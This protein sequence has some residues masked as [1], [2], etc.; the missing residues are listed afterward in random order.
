MEEHADQRIQNQSRTFGY[1]RVGMPS[2]PDSFLRIHPIC[3]RGY[4]EAGSISGY[5]G[6]RNVRQFEAEIDLKE[7]DGVHWEGSGG[8][9]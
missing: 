8:L 6:M 1:G 2:T 5:S 7:T 4:D 9:S 3:H